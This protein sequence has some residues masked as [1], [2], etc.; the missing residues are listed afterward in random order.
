[1]LKCYFR[2]FELFPRDSEHEAP[3]DFSFLTKLKLNSMA[4][5]LQLTISIE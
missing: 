2:M 4:L 3:K 5:V 1:V